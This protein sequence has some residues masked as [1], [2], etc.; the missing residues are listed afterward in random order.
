MADQRQLLKE[1]IDELDK[2]IAEQEERIPPHSVQ[3]EHIQKLEDLEEQRQQ[4]ME[5]LQSLSKE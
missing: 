4:L 2:A 3:P 1:K 5:Q